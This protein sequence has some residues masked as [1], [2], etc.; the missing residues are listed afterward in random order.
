M[1]VW[2]ILFYF[3]MFS[4]YLLE[5]FYFLMQDQKKKKMALEGRGGEVEKNWKE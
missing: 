4:C 2:F 1:V 3:V 5:A